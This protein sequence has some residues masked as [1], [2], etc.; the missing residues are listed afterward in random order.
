MYQA[1]LA[2]LVLAVVA[3][4]RPAAD[5]DVDLW[6]R[7]DAIA[8]DGGRLTLAEVRAPDAPWR[9]A[10]TLVDR[11]TATRA[12]PAITWFRLRI[13]PREPGAYDLL[14]SWHTL[15]AELFVPRA[16]GGVETVHTGGDVPTAD[17]PFPHAQN[18]IPLP[19]DALDGRPIY[20]RVRSSFAHASVFRLMSER[21]WFGWLVEGA[22]TRGLQLLSAGFVAAF[23]VLNVLLAL[24]LRRSTYAYY[25]AAVVAAALHVLVL[26]GDAWRWLWP[27]VGID[28]DLADNTTYALAIGSA[29]VFGRAFLRTRSTFP[30]TD[31]LILALLGLFVLTNVLLVVAPELLIGAGVWDWAE[32]VTTALVLAPLALCGIVAASRGDREAVL[33]AL[34]VVGVMLGNVIGGAGINLLVQYTALLHVAPTLGFAWEALLLS[35]ALAERLR[36]FEHDAFF[37][38]LTRLTNRRGLERAMA[39]ERAHA[40][41]THAPYSVLVLDVDKFKSYND[42]Y[43]HLAGD[44]ALSAVATAFGGALRAVDCAARFGG[45]E[46]VALLPGTDIEGAVALGERVRRAVRAKAIPHADGVDGVLTVSIGAACA[47]GDEPGEALLERADAALYAAKHGGRDRVEPA[48]PALA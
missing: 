12:H 6:T 8:D 43:G 25:A 2:A 40:Q 1:V 20:L 9:S 13:R 18:L 33:Y 23:G 5:T 28:Y 31:A 16:D 14:V 45:E 4:L 41:R 29:V 22:G 17:K 38:P 27:G 42:R 15:D 46:F 11:H 21:A 32:I 47:L 35:I 37:D 26:S 36:T 10:P 34:A 3:P 39:E 48:A 44:Q 19:R 30:R 7:A 24:R